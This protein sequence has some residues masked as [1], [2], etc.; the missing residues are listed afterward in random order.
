MDA[1]KERKFCF[2][3]LPQERCILLFI[4]FYNLFQGQMKAEKTH[5]RN[6]RR[7]G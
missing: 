5:G 3:G 6:Q 1:Q 4:S 7:P 2:Y